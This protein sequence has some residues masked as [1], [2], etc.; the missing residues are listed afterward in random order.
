[1]DKNG[2]VISYPIM[3]H[4]YKDDRMVVVRWSEDKAK[5]KWNLHGVETEI[6]EVEYDEKENLS[7]IMVKIHKWI[8]HQIRAHLSVIWYPICGDILY[9]KSKNQVFDKLQLFSVGMSIDDAL[10]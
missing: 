2:N 8:R 9:C 7:I 10:V 5:W 1:V 4:R 6:C 3:H